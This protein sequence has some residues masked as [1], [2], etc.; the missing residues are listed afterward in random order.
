MPPRSP[1]ACCGPPGCAAAA[2]ARMCSPG[3]SP[4]CPCSSPTP[5]QH[6]VVHSQIIA[7]VSL[8]QHRI[9]ESEPFVGCPAATQLLRDALPPYF[10]GSASHAGSG[11]PRM[12]ASDTCRSVCA[13]R[14]AACE[15]RALALMDTPAPQILTWPSAAAEAPAAP[16][17]QICGRESSADW[18]PC[19]HLQGS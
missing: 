3:W 17:G 8:P 18:A 1:V 13:H 19:V 5:A 14:G 2:T 12:H 10:I 11:T 9:F 4:G 15:A 16:G 7:P 6:S